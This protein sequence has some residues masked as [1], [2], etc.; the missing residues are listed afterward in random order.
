M[1]LRIQ[2]PDIAWLMR[3]ELGSFQS[4]LPTQL[5]RPPQPSVLFTLSLGFA[6]GY[7]LDELIVDRR[8]KLVESLLVQSN[9][10]VVAGSHKIDRLE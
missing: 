9:I 7:S 8:E 6:L 4:G 5:L 10:T 1:A 3:A 2:L